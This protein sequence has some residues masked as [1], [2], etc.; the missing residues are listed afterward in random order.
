MQSI[1]YI[2]LNNNVYSVTSTLICYQ[3]MKMEM[4]SSGLY[5]GGEEKELPLAEMVFNK[6]IELVQAIIEDTTI[7]RTQRRML[8]AML[9]VDGERWI[10]AR[11]SIQSD[12]QTFLKE[13]CS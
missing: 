10:I 5:E 1:K 7:H 6:I 4:S 13:I 2:D 9:Y 11:S 8:T 3:P 12:L